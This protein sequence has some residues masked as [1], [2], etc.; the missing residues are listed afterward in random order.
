MGEQLKVMIT[1][2]QDRIC[3]LSSQNK[4]IAHI[5]RVKNASIEPAIKKTPL[6]IH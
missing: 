5:L 4:V 3:Q 6:C 2:S 1:H